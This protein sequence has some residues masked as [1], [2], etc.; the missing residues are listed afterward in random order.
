MRPAREV[1]EEGR[2]LPAEGE[3]EPDMLSSLWSF[4]SLSESNGEVSSAESSAPSDHGDI[5]PETDRDVGAT[6]RRPERLSRR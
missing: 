4:S 1:G 6:D 5:F 2:E 3:E